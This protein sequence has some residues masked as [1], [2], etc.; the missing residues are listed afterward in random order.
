MHPKPTF[1]THATADHPW[2]LTFRSNDRT[3]CK[4]YSHLRYAELIEGASNGIQIK[5]TFDDWIVTL[6]GT[7]FGKLWDE[8]RAFRLKEVAVT[9]L[10]VIDQELTGKPARCHIEAIDIRSR[11]DDD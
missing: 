1:E 10:S 3:L 5:I 7:G 9:S 8:L 2:T 6:K 4:P 11:D